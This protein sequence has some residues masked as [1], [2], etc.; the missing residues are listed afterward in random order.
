MGIKKSGSVSGMNNPDHISEKL[1]N[2]F[3]VKILTF[4]DADPGWKKFGSGIRDK[5]LRDEKLVIPSHQREMKRS[6]LGKDRSS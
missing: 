5:V 3:L 4:L 1:K 6:D 2:N